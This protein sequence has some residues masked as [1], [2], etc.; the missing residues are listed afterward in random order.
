VFYRVKGK[1]GYMSPEQAR[2]DPLDSRSDLYSLA[3]CLYEMIT[4]E[5][6]FVQAGITTSAAEIYSQPVPMLSRKIEGVPVDLDKV[7]LK[8]LSLDP[9][10]R[11]Q[12]AGEF[13]EALARIAHRHGLLMSATDLADHLREACGD[14]EHWRRIDATSAGG[15]GGTEMYDVG[16]EGEGTEQIA[17]SDLG[18][19]D[20]SAE[21]IEV[22][23][24]ERD[25]SLMDAS[26][27]RRNRQRT[28][29]TNLTRLQGLELTSMVNMAEARH[30][31][32]QPLVDLDTLSDVPQPSADASSVMIP[33]P[34]APR[35][36]STGDAWPR[37]TPPAGTPATATPAPAAAPAR[38]PR[39]AVYP[40]ARQAARSRAAPGRPA[41]PV[42]ALILL[43]G[44]G[45]AVA[46]GMSGPDLQRPDPALTPAS[47]PSATAPG[48]P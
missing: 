4:G 2:S 20:D 45:I 26:E 48:A 38:E 44:V 18:V 10:A 5:R 6:L 3:V 22:V 9:R 34:A 35:G 8:A 37:D 1:V 30:A 25:P 13:Q 43:A 46:I 16:D 17:F 33:A 28:A 15:G 27:R 29:V 42:I 7:L 24:S 19:A 11:Y 40:V 21:I 14:P 31:G 23:H 32:A 39:R 12:T 36:R 47:V 41:W